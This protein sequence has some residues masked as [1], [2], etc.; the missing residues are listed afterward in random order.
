MTAQSQNDS[1]DLQNYIQHQDKLFCVTNMTNSDED[2]PS[3]QTL[4]PVHSHVPLCRQPMTRQLDDNFNV[5]LIRCRAM[6]GEP[7]DFN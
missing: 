5:A 1:V 7:K 6:L 4:C 2:P 3:P